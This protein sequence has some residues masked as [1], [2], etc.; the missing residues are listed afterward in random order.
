MAAIADHADPRYEV[1]VLEQREAQRQGVGGVMQRQGVGTEK[2]GEERQGMGRKYGG[3]VWEQR[4]NCAS[5][6]WESIGESIGRGWRN[7]TVRVCLENG[8]EM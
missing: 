1:R 5:R 2:Q 6:V 4:D 3:R 8:D 7:V